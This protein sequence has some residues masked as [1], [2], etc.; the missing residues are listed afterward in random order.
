MQAHELLHITEIDPLDR[1][2]VF[3]AKAPVTLLQDLVTVQ[4]LGTV[5]AGHVRRRGFLCTR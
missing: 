4:R 1:E 3:A 2:L 5:L